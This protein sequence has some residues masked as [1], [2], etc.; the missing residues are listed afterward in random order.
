MTPPR[1]RPP[2][3]E[4]HRQRDAFLQ[5]FHAAGLVPRLSTNGGIPD[6]DIQIVKA[7]LPA[8]DGTGGDGQYGEVLDC[9]VTVQGQARLEQAQRGPA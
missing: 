5:Q 1:E 2:R 7:L 4:A 6:A 8:K 9:W 3:T